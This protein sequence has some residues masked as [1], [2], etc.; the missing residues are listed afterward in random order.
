M[1]FIL[2]AIRKINTIPLKAD[3][4]I[5][6]L[7]QYLCPNLFSAPANY[8]P[9]VILVNHA[10]AG[11]NGDDEKF[12]SVFIPAETE[13]RRKYTPDYDLLHISKYL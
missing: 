4:E 6:Q 11:E 13:F 5:P 8:T 1:K 9:N 12:N 10:D 2:I 7:L 3:E